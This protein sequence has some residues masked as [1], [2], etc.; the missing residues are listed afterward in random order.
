MIL[1]PLVHAGECVEQRDGNVFVVV[2]SN[3]DFVTWKTDRDPHV[4]RATGVQVRA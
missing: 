3:R 4:E 2:L 1:D